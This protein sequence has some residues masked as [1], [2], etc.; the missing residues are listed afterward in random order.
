MKYEEF[1]AVILRRRKID[2]IGWPEDIPF[3]HPKKF[4]KKKDLYTIPR[5]L[6]QRK[7]FFKKLVSD[8]E[9]KEAEELWKVRRSR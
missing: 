6:L 7:I 8:E 5:L 2:L 9:L 4:K 3:M 1:E